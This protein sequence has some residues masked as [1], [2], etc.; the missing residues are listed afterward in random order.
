MNL[1]VKDAA[2]LLNVSEKSIY[3]WIRDRSMPC[4]RIQDQYR[5]NRSELLEWAVS[6]KIEV[7]PSIFNEPESRGQ[8]LPSISEAL[9][10]GGIIYRVE[11]TTRDDVLL[12]MVRHMNVPDNV[13]KDFLFS[14]LQAREDLGSTGIGDGIAIPHVRNPVVLHISQPSI[15]LCFLENPIEFASLDGKPVDII[16]ALISP[17]IRGHLHMLSR[18]MFMLRDAGFRE[19]LRAQGTREQIHACFQET[20]V[21]LFPEERHTP[22]K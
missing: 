1:G 11:G 15:T 10:A 4:M 22:P 2:K 9:E 19:T 13:D 16:F 8:P 17:T 21:R 3:R 7:S 12:S 20:E 18:L 14:V 6:R 5:F